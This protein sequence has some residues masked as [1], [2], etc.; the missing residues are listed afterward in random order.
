MKKF[1]YVAVAAIAALLV[2]LGFT[3]AAQAYPDVQINLDATKQVV[4]GGSNFTATA[5]ANVDCA[6]DLEWNDETRTDDGTRFVT[7]Y[8]APQ[9]SE[10]T[11]VAL[12]GIC[13]YR[14]PDSADSSARSA[15]GLSTWKRQITVTVLPTASAA[16]SPANNSSNL[17]N[18]G[19]PNWVF[20][21]SGLVLRLAGASAVTLA[22]RRAEAELPAQTA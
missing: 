22:R 17:P 4:Y 5:T 1:G 18:T 3:G 7:V 13:T 9:V 8:K 11:K 15:A 19:G 21:A 16:A 12:T 14:A 6:W 20:L 10:I 2:T